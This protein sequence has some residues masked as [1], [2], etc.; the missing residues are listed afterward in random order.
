MTKQINILLALCLLNGSL[1]YGWF[2]LKAREWTLQQELSAFP[3]VRN[4]LVKAE[5]RLQNCIFPWNDS[6]NFA[7][8]QARFEEFLQ[9]ALQTNLVWAPKSTLS[10]LRKGVI[11]HTGHVTAFFFYPQIRPFLKTL[12][13]HKL[14][15]FIRSLH[16]KRNGLNNA[17]FKISLTVEVAERNNTTTINAPP[18][19]EWVSG[20]SLDTPPPRHLFDRCL[21][22]CFLFFNFVLE[23][24]FDRRRW[25][26][27]I[28]NSLIPSPS[29]CKITTL[30]ALANRTA[31]VAATPPPSLPKHS[32]E[33]VAAVFSDDLLPN[34]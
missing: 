33:A 22:F 15:L 19:N 26:Q 24:L 6:Q 3:T 16:L 11:C 27:K 10:H 1:M 14:P 4:N 13:A 5:K 25:R 12:S 9:D 23:I 28:G 21:S 17:G 29:T 31:S 2:R 20:G 18:P 8:T 7:D 32:R 30:K 34:E